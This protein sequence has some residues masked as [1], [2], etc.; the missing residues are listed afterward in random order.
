[1]RHDLHRLQDWRWCLRWMVA[2]L[3]LVAGGAMAADVDEVQALVRHANLPQTV[4]VRPGQT[5]ARETLKELWR[6]LVDSPVTPS[7][8]APRT[9]LAYLV[10]ESLAMGQSP[11]YE[12]WL[13][14][15][16]SFRPLVVVS[17]DGYV[18]AAL[19]GRA[20][21]RLGTLR[22][23]QGEL[24]V[25]RLR[26]GTFYWEE[27]GV[28][29][30]VDGSLLRQGLPVGERPLGRDVV[31]AFELGAEQALGE[32]ARGMAG[33]ITHP[34]QALEGLSQ[35]PVA[36]GGLIA[37]S[38]E[39]FARYTDL[40]LEEQVKE[41]GRLTTHLLTLR[42]GA[43][44]VGPKLASALRMPVLGVSAQGA[45]VLREV[46]VPAGATTAVVG[47]GAASVSITLMAGGGGPQ[48]PAGTNAWIPPSGGPGQW[49]QKAES[50]A[51]EAQ[52]YQT[53]VT[54]APEGWVYRVHTGPGPKDVVDFDGFKG[55]VLLEVKG[56]G[57]QELF[58]KMK[59]K[60]WFEGLESMLAQAKNQYS[61]A[62]GSPI[63]WHFAEKEVADFIRDLF[64]KEGLEDIQ[65][66]HTAVVP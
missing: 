5:L 46:M 61:A 26:V 7:S 15:T 31:T 37:H 9:V 14:R 57:Y 23:Q 40:P 13:E 64:Q 55:G 60:K 21:A 33:L 45:L 16:R 27:G 42:G 49:E 35:L 25:Q 1:M 47:A 30:G 24:Y 18:R 19:T 54:G 58:R 56:P 12:Q 17:P 41:A 6:G 28:F 44:L 36:V 3:V 51:P 2:L 29:Y 53:Q 4:E 50:M 62:R 8:F 20:M 63:Q 34:V 43:E 66:I 38:P 48:Q 39:Y 59:G 22:L 10:R 52:R 65:V 11:T 32:M